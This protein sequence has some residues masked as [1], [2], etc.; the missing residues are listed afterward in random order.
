[1]L[2]W[3]ISIHFTWDPSHIIFMGC[4]YAALTVLG[5]G[6]TFVTIKTIRQLKLKKEK[7]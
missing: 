4:E 2:P 6:L 5:I 7:H 1:M 3:L